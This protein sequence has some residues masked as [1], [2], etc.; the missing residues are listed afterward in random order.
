MKRKKIKPV[1]Y[2]REQFGERLKE[3][4]DF[5]KAVSHHQVENLI[6]PV[7]IN[8]A[9]RNEIDVYAQAIDMESGP[10][11]VAHQINAFIQLKTTY[12]KNKVPMK[13]FV[14]SQEPS[15]DVFPKQHDMWVQ[16]K[17]SGFVNY[18]DLSESEDILIYAE[19]HGVI[20]LS[21]ANQ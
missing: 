5:N 9:G 19:Q 7:R 12:E 4:Y 18:V 3:H 8:F 16:L 1:E 21:K 11:K 17:S 20:P 10:A 14:I 2:I 6:T 13:D 15:K